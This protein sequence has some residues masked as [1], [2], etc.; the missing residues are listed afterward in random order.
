MKRVFQLIA[1]ATISFAAV[2]CSGGSDAQTP[3][4]V[5]IGVDDASKL[6]HK[7]NPAEGVKTDVKPGADAT[8]PGAD[9]AKPGGA[10]P[11]DAAKPGDA[12]KPAETKK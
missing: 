2:A 9:A 12:A 3:A 6:R 8:K 10:K 7:P 1:L 5:K 11:A 4:I